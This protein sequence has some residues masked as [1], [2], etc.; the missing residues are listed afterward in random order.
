MDPI[1]HKSACVGNNVSIGADCKI[2]C[3]AVILD[4]VK[5]GDN[6]CIGH[7]V[8]IHEGVRIGKDCFVD[9]GSILGRTPRTGATSKNKAADALPPLEIGT[10]CVI[11]ACAIIYQGTKLGNDVMVGD[12]VSIR[13]KNVIGDGTIIGRM[14]T[15]EPRTVIGRNV[16]TAAVTH[17]TSD[18]VIEDD[19]FVGSHISTTNDNTMGRTKGGAYKG[20]CFKRGS[21]I[22]SNTT[23]L[24]GVTVGANAV[25]AAGAVVTKDVPEGKLVMGVPAK[26]IR[27]I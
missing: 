18:M 1:I 12:L 13:E 14:V 20:P 25:V 16:R 9:D 2:G 4:N 17:L 7:N 15:M 23:F 3:N 24:P 22:G 5:I 19:V 26:V 8:V 27:D 11:S 21:R 10:G 6:T